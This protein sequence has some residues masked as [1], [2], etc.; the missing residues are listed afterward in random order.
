M[1]V[2][3]MPQSRSTPG[4]G[5]WRKISSF[6]VETAFSSAPGR[7]FQ[8][9]LSNLMI[10]RSFTILDGSIIFHLCGIPGTFILVARGAFARQCIN[11]ATDG[12]HQNRCIR[13]EW[14]MGG[15]YRAGGHAGCP[16]SHY[17]SF[18]VHAKLI[19]LQMTPLCIAFIS[20]TCSI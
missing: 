9:K 19:S 2:L 18:R 16:S 1:C 13:F 11:W 4:A 17:L 14:P 5:S 15:M 3:T 7:T 20:N 12:R 8:A 10:S 6:R